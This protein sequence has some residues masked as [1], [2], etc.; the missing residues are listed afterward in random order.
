MS[1]PAQIYISL[2][3]KSNNDKVIYYTHIYYWNVQKKKK[4]IMAEQ[5]EAL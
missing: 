3:S 4:I 2:K 5:N 1:N